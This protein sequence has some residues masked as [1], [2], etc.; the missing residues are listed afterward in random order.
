LTVLDFKYKSGWVAVIP[1]HAQQY[2]LVAWQHQLTDTLFS[3]SVTCKRLGR[4]I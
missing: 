1:A 4:P 3:A 2:I